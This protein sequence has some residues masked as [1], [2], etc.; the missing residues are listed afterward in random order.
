VT[1]LLVVGFNLVMLWLLEVPLASFVV[2]PDWRPR[3]IERA[4]LWVDRHAHLF[5]AVGHHAR[6]PCLL[7]EGAYRPN[8]SELTIER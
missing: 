8:G 2:A 4:T 3:T 6:K 1:V 5:A 7:T